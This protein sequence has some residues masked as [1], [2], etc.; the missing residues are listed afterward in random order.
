MLMYKAIDKE[1]ATEGQRYRSLGCKIRQIYLGNRLMH[2]YL[3]A[4]S[5]NTKLRVRGLLSQK[6]GFYACKRYM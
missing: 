5:H 6:P 1:S 2:T 3:S 4:V